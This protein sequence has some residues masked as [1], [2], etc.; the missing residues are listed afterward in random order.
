M[1]TELAKLILSEIH[2]VLG[3][4]CEVIAIRSDYLVSF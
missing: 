1:K 3:D 4:I 2:S